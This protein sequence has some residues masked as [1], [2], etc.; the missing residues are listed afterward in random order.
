MPFN[1]KRLNVFYG[2]WIVAASFFIGVFI[3]GVIFYGFTAI[4]EPIA[5]ET[6]WSYAQVSLAASLRGMEMGILAPLVGI[7]VDRLGP[8]RLIFSGGIFAALGLFLL[9]KATSLPMLYGAYL[10]IMN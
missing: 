7:L 4:F 10:P 5:Q 3:V 1:G 8:R 6:G 9:S 2:W